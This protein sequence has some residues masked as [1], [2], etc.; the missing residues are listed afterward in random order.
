MVKVLNSLFQKINIMKQNNNMYKAGTS[1]KYLTKKQAN[2]IMDL[3]I[4]NNTNL[5][6]TLYKNLR[7]VNIDN[8]YYIKYDFKKNINSID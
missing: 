6:D 2:H 1:I 3:M 7:V 8:G 4:D 5:S